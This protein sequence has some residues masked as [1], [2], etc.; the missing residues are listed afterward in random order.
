MEESVI[1]QDILRKG[2]LR[3]ELRGEFKGELKTVLRILKH[4]FG[5]LA[6]EIE[7]QIKALNQ[8]SLDALSI[9]QIDFQ[10]L[11]DLENWLAAR[12]TQM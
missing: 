4:R 6:P 10:Q 5:A 12:C 2:E 11:S 8:D 1:Y 7:S 9:A 3:G